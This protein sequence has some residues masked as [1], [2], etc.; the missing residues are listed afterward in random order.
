M[1]KVNR[2][3]NCSLLKWRLHGDLLK[4][5]KILRKF[6]I[7]NIDALFI[8]HRDSVTRNSGLKLNGKRFYSDIEKQLVC[9]RIP[10]QMHSYYW[11][12]TT[13]IHFIII[14]NWIITNSFGL[15]YTF[16]HQWKQEGKPEFT[17][18]GNCG[19]NAWSCERCKPP[20]PTAWTSCTYLCCCWCYYLGL[21]TCGRSKHRNYCSRF[22][23]GEFM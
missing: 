23:A 5:F 21:W 20:Q 13:F 14:I 22:T 8:V 18:N 3:W 15:Q 4:G 17:I 7:A 11:K 19:T 2:N 6:D 10:C 1:R 9:Y 12:F 16:F